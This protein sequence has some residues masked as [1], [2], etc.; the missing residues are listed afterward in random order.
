MLLHRRG[1]GLRSLRDIARSPLTWIAAV[2]VGLAALL[3]CVPAHAQLARIAAAS[4]PAVTFTGPWW[5]DFSTS[6]GSPTIAVSTSIN[7][8]V[9]NGLTWTNAPGSTGLTTALQGAATLPGLK[10]ANNNGIFGYVSPPTSAAKWVTRRNSYAGAQA[11]TRFA[12]FLTPNAASDSWSAVDISPLSAS[13]VTTASAYK[14]K[15]WAAQAG[16]SETTSGGNTSS[17]ALNILFHTGDICQMRYYQSAGS[18]VVD[19]YHNGQVVSTGTSITALGLAS[20]PSNFG[21]QAFLTASNP[22]VGYFQIGDPGTQGLISLRAPARTVAKDSNGDLTLHFFGDYTGSRLQGL[23][24]TVYDATSWP[25]SA[26]GTASQAATMLT[27]SGGTFSANAAKILAANIPTA[28]VFVKICR[29][30]ITTGSPESCSFSPIQKAGEVIACSGQSLCQL[31]ET[32]S[33]DFAYPLAGTVSTTVD[34]SCCSSA[35]VVST[36]ETDSRVL[37]TPTSGSG[38]EIPG[39]SVLYQS[40]LGITNFTYLRAGIGG[41]TRETAAVPGSDFLTSFI[42]GIQ[43]AGGDINRIVD[44]SGQYDVEAG[45]CTCLLTYPTNEGTIYTALEAVV[46]HQIPVMLEQLGATQGGTP[47][48]SYDTL[49]REQYNMSVSGGRYCLGTGFSDLSHLTSQ[50]YHLIPV[51]NTE[52]QRREAMGVLNCRQGG[53][54]YKR[55][56]SLNSA[57][58]TDDHTLAVLLDAPNAASV[59]TFNTGNATYGFDQGFNFGVWNGSSLTT[60]LGALHATSVSCGSVS[61]SQVTCTFGFSGTPFAGSLHGAVTGPRGSNPFNPANDTTINNTG[62]TNKDYWA[63]GMAA[64]MAVYPS[65]AVVTGSTSTTTL[66][67]SAVTSGTLAVG[68]WLQVGG[69]NRSLVITALGTGTGGTGTYTI[70]QSPALG[71]GTTLT[72]A[73]PM[74]PIQTYFNPSGATDGSQ[75]YVTTP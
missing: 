73:E 11:C 45:R 26:I 51:G 10:G 54:T 62:T 21:F 33:A 32:D 38:S 1:G 64:L 25:G 22:S 23:S 28:G 3:L 31:P 46:G 47:N 70:L 50:A 15:Y 71:A 52:L 36:S 72:A 20:L 69:S 67:V 4:Q 74:Q 14:V 35:A 8:R 75:D 41:Q 7:G 16:G 13:N 6:V 30:D 57:T 60:A 43:R 19:I 53:T 59:A 63:D 48:S 65:T 27:A 40:T 9:V 68:N 29:I 2:G 37:P 49:R 56:L 5:D 61:S 17:P 18:V 42:T 24:Y 39:F 58:E 34:A 66:T 55:G 44:N 12:D